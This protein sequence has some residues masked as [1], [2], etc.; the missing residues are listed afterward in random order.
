MHSVSEKLYLSPPES[1]V[2]EYRKQG[3]KR[4]V[5]KVQL[6]R[7]VK[8]YKHCEHYV[9]LYFLIG[10]SM[11]CYKLYF[12]FTKPRSLALV[13]LLNCQTGFMPFMA[14]SSRKRWGNSSDSSRQKSRKGRA[15]LKVMIG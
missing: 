4:E 3:A 12:Y 14:T 2:R 13:A 1:V 8:F 7:I 11:T 6:L 9:Y 5:I 10:Y 15:E